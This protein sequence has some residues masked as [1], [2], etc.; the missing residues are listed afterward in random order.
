LKKLSHFNRLVALF[1]FILVF[2]L[3]SVSSAYAVDTS[4]DNC[5]ALRLAHCNIIELNTNKYYGADRPLI[6]F[7]PGAG[8]CNSLQNTIGFVR[9]Y[10]LYNDLEVDVIVVAFRTESFGHQDWR[11]VSEDLLDFLS[12][13]Y[14][15][16][17]DD[18]RFPVIVD[19][20][21]FGGYGGCY[22]TDLFMKNS[23][24]VDE[25]NI[26]DG[27]WAFCIPI[28]WV[29]EMALAGTKINVF[30]CPSSGKISVQTRELI[31][32]LDG[33]YNFYGTVLQTSHGAVLSTAIHEEGLHSEWAY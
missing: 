1:L 25:L 5:N 2:V 9:S 15:E 16:L 10:E 12:D 30:A 33:A 13:R 14:Y 21:S 19:A 29:E 32:A 28:D 23:I 7:F 24:W 26:A 4:K 31:D 18:D 6:I 3:S 11:A 20:V 22:L 17:S 8:E 27:R